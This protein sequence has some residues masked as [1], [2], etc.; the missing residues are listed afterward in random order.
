VCSSREITTWLVGWYKY[1][2]G[3]KSVLLSLF[4]ASRRRILLLFARAIIILS[5]VIISPRL[6]RERWLLLPRLFCFKRHPSSQQTACAL[7]SPDEFTDLCLTLF[8]K[9]DNLLTYFMNDCPETWNGAS[10][11]N[12]FHFCAPVAAV[13]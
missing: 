10:I 1:N 6:W 7:N 2:F 11:G 8:C 4:K 5:Q 12:S 9:P 3:S 13:D